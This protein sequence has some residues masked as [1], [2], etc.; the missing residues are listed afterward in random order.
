MTIPAQL[1]KAR[2]RLKLAEA[3]TFRFLA[4]HKG[5]AISPVDAGKLQRLLETEMK[6]IIHLT[7]SFR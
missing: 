1:V 5:H 7:D 6:A 3:A 2:K 4:V